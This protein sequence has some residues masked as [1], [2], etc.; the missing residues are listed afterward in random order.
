MSLAHKGPLQ[1][2]STLPFRIYLFII[3]LFPK[4]IIGVFQNIINNFIE[5]FIITRIKNNILST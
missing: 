4:T 1:H 5:N 3:Y 2:G